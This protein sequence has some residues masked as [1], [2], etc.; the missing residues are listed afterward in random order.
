[1][2]TWVHRLASWH[3]ACVVGEERKSIRLRLQP[4]EASAEAQPVGQVAVECELPDVSIRVDG[5]VVGTTPLVAPLLV[6]T[7]THQVV[8]ERAGYRPSELS[9]AVT[10]GGAESIRCDLAALVP[11]SDAAGARLDVVPGEP[12]AHVTVDGEPFAGGNLPTGRHVVVVRRAGFQTFEQEVELGPG[13]PQTLSPQLVPE[14]EYLTD[15]QARARSQRTA[16]Y[17]L[18]GAGVALAGATVVTFL[19]ADAKHSDWQ[20]RQSALDGEWAAGSNDSTL[21][22]RQDDNDDRLETV[23]TLDKV[24]VGL[25]VAAGGLLVS[26]AV[27][28]LTGDDPEKYSSVTTSAT[29]SGGW[30]GWRGTW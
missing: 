30:V 5:D 11:L 27:L 14:P 23:Q 24:T 1:M 4:D 22:A 8:M 26:G 18:G 13:Q 16:A 25:G 10:A 19:V 17:V 28:L 9:V 20:D 6:P 21:Q 7:G 2:R 29:R 3:Q 15:Y 12:G